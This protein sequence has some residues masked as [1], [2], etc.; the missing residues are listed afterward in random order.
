ME[1]SNSKKNKEIK[2]QKRKAILLPEGLKIML[3]VLCILL[4]I[5]FGVKLYSIF[6]Q[7]TETSQAEAHMEKM[8]IL[9]DNIQEGETKEII[10]LS[11]KGW[12]IGGFPSSG[13]RNYGDASPYDSYE[14]IPLQCTSKNWKKCVCLCFD[15][16]LNSLDNT[17]NEYKTNN[18]CIS[19]DKFQGFSV[20]G[21]N[22]KISD[23]INEGKPIAIKL[24]NNELKL[25]SSK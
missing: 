20:E 2:K 23:L 15:D 4:L 9:I 24:E 17:C 18:L 6:Q 5:V 1:K 3:G 7:S 8:K 12:A 21:G 25:S 16:N 13:D 19:L 14:A 10:I 22:I 11:P